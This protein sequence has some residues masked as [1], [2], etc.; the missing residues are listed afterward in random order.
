MTIYMCVFA[1]CVTAII[2]AYILITQNSNKN[3]NKNSNVNLTFEKKDEPQIYGNE[4]NCIMTMFGECSYAE[5]GCGDCAVVEKVRKAL[6][7]TEPQ[8]ERGEW[9]LCSERLPRRDEH[10]NELGVLV[11]LGNGYSGLQY[12]TYQETHWCDWDGYVTAWMPFP[13]PYEA[14]Q[15]EP[16]TEKSRR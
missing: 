3:S 10:D 9:I 5:T 4:Y 13:K 7:Q 16:H 15:T 12:D 14:E 8:T 6:T 2:I 1:V 11:T